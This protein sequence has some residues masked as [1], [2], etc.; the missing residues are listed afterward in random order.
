MGPV[1]DGIRNS[2]PVCKLDWKRQKARCTFI[3][4]V[5]VPLRIGYSTPLRRDRVKQR[6]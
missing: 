2:T 5:F 4:M 3:L 6:A 1:L